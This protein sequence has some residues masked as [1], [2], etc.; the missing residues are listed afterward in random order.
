MY[1]SHTKK[2]SYNQELTYQLS[3][4]LT[5]YDNIREIID[6]VKQGA[7]PNAIGENG[8]N[9]LSYALEKENS[10]LYNLF[11]EYDGDVKYICNQVKIPHNHP[12]HIAA[13][14]NDE[15]GLKLLVA[16]GIKLNNRDILDSDDTALIELVKFNTLNYQTEEQTKLKN[17]KYLIDNGADMT[18]CNLAHE[19]FITSF[20]KLAVTKKAYTEYLPAF[21]YFISKGAMSGDCSEGQAYIEAAKD[22]KAMEILKTLLA[23]N[24]HNIYVQ[25][26]LWKD[27]GNNKLGID[28]TMGDLLNL[29]IEDKESCAEFVC[30]GN[31]DQ[32]L[33]AGQNSQSDF[34]TELF[35]A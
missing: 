30:P 33:C 8:Q 7:N 25:D 11:F 3:K 16:H 32:L 1:Y 5:S 26:K 2:S 9:I 4:S 18:L 17:I 31:E 20:T 10:K 14:K 35:S 19:D 12:L 22:K 21:K 24:P 6:L 13:S 23:A 29:C 34:V 15:A 27:E 28:P